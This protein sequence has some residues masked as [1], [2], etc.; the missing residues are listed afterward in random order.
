VGQETEAETTTTS[1]GRSP[2]AAGRLDSLDREAAGAYV[3]ELF[4]A[5][6]RM[7]LGLC[8]LLLRDPVE[9][10]DATQQVFLSAH[11]AVLRG[12]VP[13]E[14]AAWTAA[15]ARNE[16]RA[17][18]R[19][20]MREPLA[21]PELPSDLPDPLA[22]AIRE[23]DLQAIW[24]ALGALPR[25]Q[26]RAVVLRELGGLSYHEL[27]RALGVSHSAVESLLFRA[28]QQI[29]SLIAGAN[30]AAVPVALRDELTRLI[31]GFDPGSAGVVARLA[32]LP[33][34]WKLASTAVGI[35]VV[36]TG[37]GGLQTRHVPRAHHVQASVAPTRPVTH[38][39]IQ[40]AR[41]T[42]PARGTSRREPEVGEVETRGGHG[43][44]PEHAEAAEHEQR[45]A[46]ENSSEGPG[47]APAESVAV[48]QSHEGPSADGVEEALD[49]SGPDTSGP[50]SSGSG[51]SGG[52]D[53]SGSDSSGH[54][55][56]G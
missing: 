21:L 38:T 7:V 36:A 10:E 37:A 39:R 31:P 56:P 42:Q 40:L 17:R 8:R 55:G 49:K 29:R 32:A 34:A 18:I 20:R 19:V 13:R 53:P 4:A 24:T 16:C 27:G 30:A 1:P 54:S 52:G 12:S 47:P 50:D 26:R 14:A 35:G 11:Q 45:E 25:H 28:R 5:H 51:D 23:A 33:V 44:E 46:T 2:E 48:F 6:G 43:D 9:A 3:G 22:L 41:E 15:I